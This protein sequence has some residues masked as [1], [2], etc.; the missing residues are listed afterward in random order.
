MGATHGIK[1]QKEIPTLK[2]LNHSNRLA[3]GL[4]MTIKLIILRP[5]LFNP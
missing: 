1:E 4:R 3:R 2:G 5:F